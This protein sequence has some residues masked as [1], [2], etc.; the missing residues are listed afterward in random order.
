MFV[1]LE[2]WH[3]NDRENPNLKKNSAISIKLE[4]IIIPPLINYV[5]N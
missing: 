2:I 1:L 5:I 4:E 3:L